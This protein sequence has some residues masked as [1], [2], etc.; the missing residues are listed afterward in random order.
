MPLAVPGLVLGI[1]YVF[2]FARS[3]NPLSIIYGTMAILVI[4]TVI[5]YYPVGHLMAL[6]ALR[7]MDREFESVSASLKTP[8][9]KTFWRV[10]VPVCLPALLEM[11]TFFFMSAMNTTSAAVFLFSATTMPASVSILN[12]RLPR[13]LRPLRHR[14]MLEVQRREGPVALRHGQHRAPRRSPGRRR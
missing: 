1:S 11:S 4:S 12:M 8:F 3:D 2:F 14:R 13:A 6:T 9:Y 5:H 7:Q 10:T